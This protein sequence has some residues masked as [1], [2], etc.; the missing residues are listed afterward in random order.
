MNVEVGF[1]QRD[2][3]V[4]EG[5][6]DSI[7]LRKFVGDATDDIVLQVIPLTISGFETYRNNNPDRT[8]S[9]EFL[10]LIADVSDPADCKYQ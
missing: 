3:A 7:F 1:E 10:D 9:Q 2:A 6:N 4:T 8:F 5:R